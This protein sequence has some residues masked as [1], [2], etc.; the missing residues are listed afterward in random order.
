MNKENK[1]KKVIK[2]TTI[3][4]VILIILG[5]ALTEGIGNYFVNYAIARSGAGG[6]RKVSEE[7]KIEIQG[8]DKQ[9]IENNRKI[10]KESSKIWAIVTRIVTRMYH[11]KNCCIKWR[12]KYAGTEGIRGKADERSF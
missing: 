8:E 5:I 6:D 11:H 9:I 4:L 1:S 10:A 2:I 7:T 12:E 3:I